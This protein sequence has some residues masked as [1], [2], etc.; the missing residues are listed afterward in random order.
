MIAVL[1]NPLPRINAGQ[2]R[3]P[4]VHERGNSGMECHDSAMSQETV[5][6]DSIAD[7]RNLQHEE[8]NRNQG[9]HNLYFYSVKKQQSY[10]DHS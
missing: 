6:I 5:Q 9:N 10:R 7:H 2:Y 1:P 3:Q 8:N 4:Q